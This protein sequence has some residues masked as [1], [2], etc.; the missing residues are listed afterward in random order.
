MNPEDMPGLKF[1]FCV[2][3]GEKILRAASLLVLICKL[4]P[5]ALRLLTWIAWGAGSSPCGVENE[6][7]VPLNENA[8]LGELTS[9]CTGIVIE[10]FM[11]PDELMVIKPL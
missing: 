9:N 3:I 6:R 11:P 8:G 1:A 2:P 7:L 4:S 10:L 5:V